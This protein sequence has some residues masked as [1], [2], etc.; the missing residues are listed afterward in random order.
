MRHTRPAIGAR[1]R[2]TPVRELWPLVGDDSLRTRYSALIRGG[3][4]KGRGKPTVRANA[5]R[6]AYRTRPDK[7]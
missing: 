3:S 7:G 6:G 5:D 2:R 1:R 4:V